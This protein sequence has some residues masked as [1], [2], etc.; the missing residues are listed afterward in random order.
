MNN[1]T[2]LSVAIILVF[3]VLLNI[4]E[5]PAFETEDIPTISVPMTNK[6]SETGSV[7][8][9]S[10]DPEF[11][12]M[13]KLLLDYK[14]HSDILVNAWSLLIG[15]YDDADDVMTDFNL[16][17]NGGFKAYI[18]DNEEEGEDFYTLHVGPNINRETIEKI[19]NEIED[20]YNKLSKIERYRE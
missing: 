6:F 5:E 12:E 8:E 1:L 15:S 20:Q 2:Y 3:I 16:L 18:R 7:F 9:L 10:E 17:K 19:Q 4:I 14:G 13:E 11:E